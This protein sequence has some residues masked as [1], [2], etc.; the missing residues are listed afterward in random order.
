[1]LLHVPTSEFGVGGEIIGVMS[2]V[3]QANSP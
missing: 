3:C 1:M 2:V